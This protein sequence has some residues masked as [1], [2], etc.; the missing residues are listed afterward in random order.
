M[1]YEEDESRTHDEEPS[2]SYLVDKDAQRPTEQSSGDISDSNLLSCRCLREAK[3]LLVKPI[4]IIKEG[5][6]LSHGKCA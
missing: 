4:S 3:P 2:K 1:S 5:N 6:V